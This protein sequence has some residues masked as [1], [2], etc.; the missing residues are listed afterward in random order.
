MTASPGRVGRQSLSTRVVDAV[1]A[2]IA[3]NEM[4]AGDKLLSERELAEALGVS[5]SLLREALSTLRGRG[6]LTA[7]HG[8]GVYVAEPSAPVSLPF[9]TALADLN[10]PFIWETRQA[11]ETQCARM[12]ALRATAADLDELDAALD[13]M[14]AEVEAG[15]SGLDGDRRFHQAVAVAS[16]NP[17]LTSLMDSIR[18]VLDRTSSR[19]LLRPGQPAR[20]LAEHRRIAAAIRTHEAA[21]AAD[22]MLRHLIH[23][24]DHLHDGQA[25]QAARGD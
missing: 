11:L 24:T 23:T 21:D 12:A 17:I 10:L 15:L 6:R 19:S 18:E 14:A 8:K 1:E 2:Y 22:S 4:A 16:H 5:R 7:V 13:L 9:D 20:S 3:S 25:V